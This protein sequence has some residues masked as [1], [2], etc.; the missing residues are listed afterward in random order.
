MVVRRWRLLPVLL[1]TLAGLLGCQPSDQGTNPDPDQVDSIEA[2]KVGA[3]RSL[4]PED[5]KQPS[6]ASK[7]VDCSTAHTA[8]TFAVGGLPSRFKDAEWSSRDLGTYAYR[9]CGGKFRDF[10][11]ADESMVMRAMVSWAWFRPSEDAWQ[12]GARWYRCD[13]VGGGDQSS[14]YA[15]LPRTAE[16]LLAQRDTDKWMVCAVGPT[17]AGSKKVSCAAAHQW[18]AVT[19]IKLGEPQDAYPGDKLVQ[20]RT[21]DYCSDSVGAWLGYPADYDFAYTWF[22]Q[23][24]WDAGNR[25]SVCWAKTPK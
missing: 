15:D 10:L 9:T 20:V 14:T 2:P 13:I 4:T 1:L 16:G 24:E 12:K 22:H 3:C 18:R 7:V 17:V 5:V 11:G 23:A 19:S 21:R 8:E 25:L 6:N